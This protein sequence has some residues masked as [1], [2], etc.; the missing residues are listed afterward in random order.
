MT[1]SAYALISLNQAKSYLKIDPAYSLHVDA[2]YVGTG[3][4]TNVTFTLDNP[5]IEGTLK[6]YVDSILKTVNTDYA[7]SGST[8][9]FTSSGK[10]GNGKIVTAAYDKAASSGSFNDYEDAE[11]EAQIEALTA[12]A[13][14][15]TGRYFVQRSITEKR[16]GDG[17]Q[18]LRLYKRPVVSI[19]SVKIE[20]EALTVDSDYLDKTF[21]GR[22]YREI[23]WDKDSE[24]EIVYTA[25]SAATMELA[26]PLLPEAVRFVLKALAF[27][28]E[29]RT[30]FK[31]QNIN[32]IGSIDYELEDSLPKVIVDILNPLKVGI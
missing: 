4:G 6:V 25:G 7:V 21:M 18:V 24:I 9:T 23:G 13:E 3:N 29:N 28:Y 26:Q 20:G 31:S 27:D 16:M 12:F 22:L 15:R 30:G 19:T 8:I 5:P 1:L 2:E 11:I 17:G 14:K 32:G 10:P